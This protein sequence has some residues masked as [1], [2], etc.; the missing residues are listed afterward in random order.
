MPKLTTNLPRIIRPSNNQTH[1]TLR[2]QTTTR[3]QP[4]ILQ[5]MY[6][7][8]ATC[9]TS[10]SV[11]GYA[12]NTEAS[13]Y[14][15][16]FCCCQQYTAAYLGTRWCRDPYPACCWL[17]LGADSLNL[18]ELGWQ[19]FAALHR[20]TMTTH[21]RFHRSNTDTASH[22]HNKSGTTELSHEGATKKSFKIS[23]DHSQ[24]VLH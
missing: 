24:S 14:L 2:V 16:P 23:H 12:F 15:A 18:H 17:V 6:L 7:P 4:C 19:W 13:S 9:N 21:L 8:F 22:N 5:N 1:S 10:K 11:G 20:S 3:Y